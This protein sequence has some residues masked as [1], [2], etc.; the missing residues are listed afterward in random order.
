MQKNRPTP[1]P[2]C[3]FRSAYLSTVAYGLLTAFDLWRAVRACVRR[4]RRHRRQVQKDEMKD[5]MVEP[6]S[7]ALMP[8][9]APLILI[10]KATFGITRLGAERRR[11]A[12]QK[13]LYDISVRAAAAAAA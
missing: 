10:K 5:Y 4:R 1:P 11:A 7:A 2:F 6:L 8:K 9:F 3:G 13:D 12:L